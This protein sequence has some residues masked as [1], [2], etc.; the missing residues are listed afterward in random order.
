MDTQFS[1]NRH[2]PSYESSFIKEK[3]PGALLGRLEARLRNP[4]TLDMEYEM[5]SLMDLQFALQADPS[6]KMTQYKMEVTNLRSLLS[7]NMG[8]LGTD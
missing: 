1:D 2:M 6:P 5:Q 7:I 4:F 3:T 8:W